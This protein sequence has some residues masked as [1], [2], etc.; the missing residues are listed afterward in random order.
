[1]HFSVKDTKGEEFLLVPLFC[2][3]LMWTHCTC[4][5][6][7]AVIIQ[8]QFKPITCSLQTPQFS[9]CPTLCDSMDC[10]TPGF[11]VHHQL[12]ELAQTH[13]I[14]CKTPKILQILSWEI[15]W[16]SASLVFCFHRS[17]FDSSIQNKS[18]LKWFVTCS[19]RTKLLLSLSSISITHR[20]SSRLTSS[21][22]PSASPLS[23]DKPLIG[24]VGQAEAGVSLR[25]APEGFFPYWWGRHGA[26]WARLQ[27][28]RWTLHV[29]LLSFSDHTF[30]S[31]PHDLR[32]DL[33]QCPARTQTPSVS[34]IP[35]T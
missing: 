2:F 15:L 24:T 21:T 25:S 34:N 19:N 27:R 13:L 12:P 5:C 3:C 26:H 14:L 31:H 8:H 29:T 32:R 30:L 6:L 20:I 1:M 22:L 18:H 33:L 9:S 7:G 4:S 17:P 10:S 11:P 28:P 23:P 16:L 35:P